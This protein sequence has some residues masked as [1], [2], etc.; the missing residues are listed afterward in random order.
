MNKSNKESLKNSKQFMKQFLKLNTTLFTANIRA[1]DF[2]WG[3]NLKP[4]TNNI[5]KICL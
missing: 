1:S 4:K 3:I 5:W 2:F